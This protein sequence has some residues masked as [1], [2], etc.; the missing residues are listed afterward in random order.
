GSVLVVGRHLQKITGRRAAFERHHEMRRLA[1]PVALPV[2]LDLGDTNG[3]LH[4]ESFKIE[5]TGNERFAGGVSERVVDLRLVELVRKFEFGAPSP[6]NVD[7][8]GSIDTLRADAVA[9]VNAG[10]RWGDIEGEDHRGWL[11]GDWGFDLAGRLGSRSLGREG[12]D[13]SAFPSARGYGR[14]FLDCL[15]LLLARLLW[16]CAV[17]RCVRR[18]R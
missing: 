2:E 11:I 3:V 15:G 1:G 14:R 12:F 8:L 13:L 6:M 4:F 9:G 18:R 10:L 5:F 16:R 17:G 7:N